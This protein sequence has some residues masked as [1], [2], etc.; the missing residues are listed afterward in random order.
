[1]NSELHHRILETIQQHQMLAP[2]D[3]VGVAVSGGADSVALLRVLQELRNELGIGLC[4]LHLNHALRVE[5]SDADAEFVAGLARDL[6]LEFFGARENVAAIARRQHWNLEDAGRRARYAFFEQAISQRHCTKAAVAHTADDQAETVLARI[7]RGSGPRGIVGIHP[8]RGNIVRPLLDI[9]RADLREYLRAQGQTWREDATNLDATRLRAR[10]RHELLPQVERDFNP[11][12]I[13]R[14][15]SL[16]AISR[17]EEA[18]WDVIVDE[19]VAALATAIRGGVSIAIADLLAPQAT[20]SMQLT[21]ARLAQNAD[22]ER[23]LSRRMVQALFG[24]ISGDRSGLQFSHV[25]DV[26]HL[27]AKSQSGRRLEL[28]QEVDVLRNFDILEFVHRKS[29][30]EPDAAGTFAAKQCPYLYGV[31]LT[32]QGVASVDVPELGLRFCLKAIDWPVSE[33]DTTCDIG[34]L[35]ADCLKPPLVLRNWRP[36][37]AFRLPGKRQA[38]KLK[39][40]FSDARI[41]IPERKSWPVLTSAGRI[42]WMR[43]W[44]AAAEFSAGK[45]TRRRIVVLEEK[46]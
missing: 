14:L 40:L 19:R 10:L 35:D 37:D 27:A 42:A 32:S 46:L 11:A 34:A 20:Q 7:V 17:D 43:G 28:P 12:I 33:S 16:S 9:R 38:Q 18:F 6:N 26:L 3:R 8:V 24:K 31:N 13:E 45:Q 2:G 30:T 1:M 44:P 39:R 22:A 23:A 25:E 36:G 41:S 5:A 4:V 29:A 21:Q 15:A